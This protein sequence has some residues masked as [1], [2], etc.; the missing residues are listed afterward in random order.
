M[1]AAQRAQSWPERQ[2]VHRQFTIRWTSGCAYTQ[3]FGARDDDN[4]RWQ[5][6]AWSRVLGEVVPQ[7]GPQFVTIIDT[8]AIGEIP[9]GLWLG[10]VELA[11]TMARKPVRRALM[12]A[13]GRAGDNQAQAA[14]LVTAGN[15]R[16]FAPAQHDAMI[17]WL[18]EGGAIEA[19]R[20]R[21]FLS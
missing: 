19:G 16:I 7:L 18:A 21:Q 3:V 5:I 2:Q 12:I 8:R 17:E 14:S 1:R 10:L 11:A 9:R 15:V 13:E 4:T 20:L 6:E